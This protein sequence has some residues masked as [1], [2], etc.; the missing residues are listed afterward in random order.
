MSSFYDDL[1]DIM[2][3]SPLET[4]TVECTSESSSVRT[5]VIIYTINRDTAVALAEW[6]RRVPAKYMGFPRESSNLSGDVSFLILNIIL[7]YFSFWWY[8][9]SICGPLKFLFFSFFDQ[10]HF[11]SLFCF[12]IQNSSSLGS[13][14][15][16]SFKFMRIVV[17]HWRVHYRH[18]CWRVISIWC[19][20]FLLGTH[21][22]I[23]RLPVGWHD[24]I[25][26]FH[27]FLLSNNQTSFKFRTHQGSSLWIFALLE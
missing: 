18:V 2:F 16:L 17:H 25:I 1:S 9:L 15:P 3:Q 8:S 7:F 23:N 13:K 12:V 27:M 14:M 26:L 10:R 6:L 19:C 4:L 21:K 5:K 11:F 20:L 22:Y 24:V